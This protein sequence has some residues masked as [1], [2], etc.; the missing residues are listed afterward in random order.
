MYPAIYRFIV[1]FGQSQAQKWNANDSMAVM[2]WSIVIVDNKAEFAIMF[3][4][5]VTD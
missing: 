3:S 5:K 4:H 1:L 2:T